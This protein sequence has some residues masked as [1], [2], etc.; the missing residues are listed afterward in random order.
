MICLYKEF[1]N[2][3]IY[4]DGRVFSKYSNRFLK[5]DDTTGYLQYRLYI[6]NSSKILK[7]HRLVAQLFLDNKND[8]PVVN[9]IDGNKLNN[10]YSNLE[11]CTYEHNNRH[12][13][14]MGLN[15]V[16]KSNSVR[17]LDDDFRNRTA[18]RISKSQRESGC[19]RGKNNPKFR[20]LLLHNNVEISR[21]QLCEICNKA[22]STV[23]A[24][25][26]H[27]CNGAHIEDFEN[28]NIQVI[29]TK[30]GQST[31]ETVA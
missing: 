16:S 25:I 27:Y 31:I 23:D 15:N 26:K 2:Y 30:K 14:A 24:Y 1:H 19:S 6:N 11:W 7:A 12:A 9:H 29:D 22:Q 4:E 10:H 20:Y 13:R 3:L 17:W 18:A 21:Q 28:N 8:Y 5:G